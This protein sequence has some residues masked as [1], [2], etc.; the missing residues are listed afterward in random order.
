MQNIHIHE[1]AHVHPSA[2]IGKG[3]KIWHQ[4]QVESEAEI[5]E[6]CTLAKAVYIG[7][8]VKIGNNVKIQNR[9]SIYEGITIED[10]AFIGPHV[11]FTNDVLPR[12]IDYKGNPLRGGGASGSSEKGVEWKIEKTLVKKGASIGANST[13]LP[14]LTIGE[15]SMIGAGSVVTKD[16]PNY[17][18]VYGNPAR[19]NGYVC[20]CGKKLETQCLVCKTK[21]PQL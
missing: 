4:A 1:S 18:L 7:P 16:V 15:F 14:G 10:G 2:K 21:L 12:S 13:I 20:K 17:G 5:G 11:C 8:K 19:L 3:T 9:A 6:N